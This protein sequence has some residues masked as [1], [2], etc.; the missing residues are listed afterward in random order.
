M[1]YSLKSRLMTFFVLLSILSF[2][3]M[4]ILL[5]NQSRTIIRSNIE[6]SALEKMEE[7]GAYIDMV[8][9]QIYD[10]AS[11][12]FNS[13]VTK[14]WD[15]LTSDPTIPAGE[16]MYE[17]IKM[18]KFLT[19]ATNGYSGVSGVSIYSEDGM[20]LGTDNQVVFDKT[21]LQQ[22]WYKDFIV[23]GNHWM[24]EHTDPGEVLRNNASPVVS[25][26][27][28][29]GTF[30]PSMAQNIMKLN[31]NADYFRE[32]LNRIHLGENGTIYLLDQE[33][34]PLLSQTPQSGLSAGEPLLDKIEE[35]RRDW[36]KQ[37]VI[38]L[39]NER[40]TMDILVYKKLKLTKWML[41]GFVSEED[42]YSELFMLRKSIVIFSALLLIVSLFV[43]AGLAYSITKPLSELVSAMRLVQR[44]DFRLAENKIPPEHSIRSEIGYVTSTFRTMV[45]QLRYHIKTEF[46]LKLLR[47]QAEYKSLLMQI[48][49]HFLFNTL[50]LMS[51][52]TMQKRNDD[53]IEVIELLGKMMRYS[54]KISDDLVPL[55]EELGYVHDYVGILKIRFSDRLHITIVEEGELDN[56]TIIKFILQ[57]LI[58]N[59]VKFSLRQ[60]AEARVDIHVRRVQRRLY[61]IIADNGPG[62]DPEQLQR[63]Q[64]QMMPPQLD[65]SM[66]NRNWQI[67]LGN[68]LARCRLYY[69]S[70]FAVQIDSSRESGTRIELRLPV[71]EESQDVSGIDRR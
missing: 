46:E 39:K 40:G 47:Q 68:V 17:H 13:D 8:Q 66:L 3:T 19:Q 20:W 60:Q 49:P 38:N 1:F 27:M 33:G 57:P 41:V 54:L 30:E 63:L 52:L 48:N 10:L 62:I 31:V 24:A 32:P 71:E 9:M 21:F 55:T 56:L 53:T 44:G 58:E 43:A 64:E 11:L 34:T 12:V 6:S 45:T 35:A 61:F 5:F 14:N 4:A 50:E 26:L 18:S 69:G 70:L 16:R 2:G 23:N 36:R 7:Y 51:S 65:L 28:P 37:G 59:A 15:K 25:M 67:G 22:D 29:L 42:L